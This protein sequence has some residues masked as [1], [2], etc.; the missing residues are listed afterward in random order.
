MLARYDANWYGYLAKQRLDVLSK[1]TTKTFASDSI[2]AR[3]VANLK[4]VTV[5]EETAPEA[6]A[7]SSKRISCQTS[8]STIGPKE[9]TTVSEKAPDSPKINLALAQ[10]YRSDDDNVRALNTLRRSFPDYSQMKPGRDDARTVGR[11]LSAQLL[12]HHPSGVAGAKPRSV[13][14]GWSDSSGD[15]LHYTRSP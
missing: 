12:G 9:L 1:T 8:V 13:S 3:A 4:T 11:L 10:I 14:S 2:V 15:G 5:A 7:R 6:D